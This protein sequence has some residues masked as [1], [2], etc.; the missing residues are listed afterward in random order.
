[1]K[2]FGWLFAGP[3]KKY[4]GIYA[5]DVAFAMIKISDLPSDKMIYESDE[6]QKFI[7]M[8]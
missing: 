2:G 6:L 5:S 8:K 1:M 4:K 7:Q 3:F